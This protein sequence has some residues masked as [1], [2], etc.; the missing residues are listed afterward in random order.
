MKELFKI[1]FPGLYIIYNN[2]TH[3]HQWEY[4]DIKLHCD[5]RKTLDG[6]IL[7]NNIKKCVTCDKQQQLQMVPGKFR[8][9]ESYY[10]LPTHTN[11][12]KVKVNVY[13][14][15]NKSEVR[16]QTIDNILS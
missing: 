15:K 3:K 6:R 16:D 1:L 10:K 4:W 9:K 8:W 2:I 12:I 13:G 14:M 11:I 7:H 5:H